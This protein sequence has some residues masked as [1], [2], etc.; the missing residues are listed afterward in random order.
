[1]TADLTTRRSRRDE[2]AA[3]TGVPPAAVRLRVVHV[4]GRAGATDARRMADDETALGW[5]ARVA[6]GPAELRHEMPA[7]DV[8]VLH[9]P[10]AGLVGRLLVRGRRTTV[11]V[12]PGDRWWPRPVAWLFGAWERWAARWANAVLLRGDGPAAVRWRRRWVP[13]FVVGDDPQLR[14]AVLTRAH[15]F[16]W[17]GAAADGRGSA[18]SEA[19]PAGRVD[20]EGDAA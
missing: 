5:A 10:V 15:S 12:P 4:P 13:P 20:D 9:G 11:L 18:R 7:A 1:V 14:A 19:P 6:G 8:V 2:L 3:V 17:P 16:G